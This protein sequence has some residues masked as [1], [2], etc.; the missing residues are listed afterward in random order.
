MPWQAL[1]G[2]TIIKQHYTG[3]F[4][5]IHIVLAYDIIQY[6]WLCICID[7]YAIGMCMLLMSC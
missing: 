5:T 3:Y 6:T 1:L 4:I 2:H 7:S